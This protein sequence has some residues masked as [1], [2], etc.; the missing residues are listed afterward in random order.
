[1]SDP[2]LSLEAH[3]I[4]AYHEQFWTEMC[5]VANF[6]TWPFSLKRHI[7]SGNLAASQTHFVQHT[8]HRYMFIMS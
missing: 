6:N 4:T 2:L 5:T 7:T 1:M 3:C 8:L